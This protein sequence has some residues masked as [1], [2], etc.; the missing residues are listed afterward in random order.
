M[1]LDTASIIMTN[2]KEILTVFF[3]LGYTHIMLAFRL[4][5]VWAVAFKA[6]LVHFLVDLLALWSK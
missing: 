5:T 2:F 1:T 6:A 3:V 4:D